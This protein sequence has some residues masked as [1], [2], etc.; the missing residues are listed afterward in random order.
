LP[1]LAAG[2]GGYT[3]FAPYPLTHAGAYEPTDTLSEAVQRFFADRAEAAPRS[4]TGQAQAGLA[5]E[6][7]GALDRER[8]RLESIERQ[9]ATADEAESLRETGELL[10]AY[11]SQIPPGADRA[12]LHGRSLSLDPTLSAVENARSYFE[13]Y[14]RA[15]DAAR[16]LPEMVEAARSRVAYLTESLTHASLADSPDAVAALRRELSDADA[17][18]QGSK[19]E[20]T[21]PNRRVSQP[22]G[23]LKTT[24]DGHQLL[25]GRTAGQNAQALDLADPDDLW[26]HARGVAGAHVILRGGA[27][28]EATILKAARLAAYH[29]EARD[30]TSVPV[31]VAERRHVRKIKGGPPGAVT[32]RGEHTLSVTP[33][34]GD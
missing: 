3:E 8:R 33:T 11:A 7:R 12:D 22:A 1:S 18:G 26:L 14:T 24:V 16:R 23:P 29:S 5:G 13:R 2:E 17:L 9:L 4:T 19:V 21:R 6:I 30:A 34:R 25:I 28:S 20:P 32:Y 10:L 27:P 15:R 31:D